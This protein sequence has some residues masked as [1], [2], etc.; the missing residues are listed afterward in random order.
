MQ[1]T[2][3]K[4]KAIVKQLIVAAIS[5]LIYDTLEAIQYTQVILD[6]TM[7]AQYI[8]HN[9]ETLRYM[10]YVLYKLEKT[11]IVIE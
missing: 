2:G 9:K 1:W 8:S 10:E 3:N 7:L 11:K 6:F 4:Q 5:L